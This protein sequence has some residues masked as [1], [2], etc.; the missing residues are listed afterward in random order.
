LRATRSNKGR[1]VLGIFNDG[2]PVP[3]DTV[4][5][6]FEPF[7]TTSAGGTGLG[8]Y[9][10]REL[11]EANDASISYQPPAEGGVCFSIEFG[12]KDER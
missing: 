6:L 3:I 1:I 11:C 5:K 10:A 7:F 9:I 8:L 4:P 12:G 2:P